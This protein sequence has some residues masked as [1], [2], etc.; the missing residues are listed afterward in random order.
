MVRGEVALAESR[1]PDELTTVLAWADEIRAGRLGVRANADTADDAARAREW[2]AEGIGLCRTEHQFLGDRLPLVRRMI[3]AETDEEEA[4]ALAELGVQQ[5]RTS[6]PCSRRWT[7]CRSPCACST[8][9]C[10]SS[11]PTST[12]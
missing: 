7:A 11:C 5:R 2:G 9:R 10:T 1:L 3:L 4:A 8:R 12:S 6:R